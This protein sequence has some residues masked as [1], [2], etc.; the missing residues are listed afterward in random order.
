MKKLHRL[1]LFSFVS[2]GLVGCEDNILDIPNENNPDFARVY[3]TGPDVENVASGLYNAVF[4]GENNTNGVQ[5]MLATAADNV[6]CSFGNF[7]M[8][9]M[10]WEPRN[11]AWDNSPTY[12]NS[13]QTNNSYNRWYSAIGTASNVLRAIDGGVQIGANGADNNRTRAFAKFTLGLAY[14]NLALVFDRA[15]IVDETKTVDAALETA[16]PYE[17]VASAAIAYLEEALALSNESFTIPASWLG[18]PADVSSAD[19][20]KIINTSAARILSYLPRNNAAVVDVDWARVRAYA[21][22]GITADW[23]VLQDG[24]TRW[25][26]NSGDYLRRVGWGRTDMYV[27]NMMEPSLPAYWED[28]GDFPTPPEPATALDNRLKT[29]FQYMPSNDFIADRGYYHFSCYRLKRYD[30]VFQPNIGSKP[31]VA[32]AENDMLRAEA[33]AYLGDLAGAAAIINAGTRVTRGNLD[34]VAADFDDIIEAIHHERHVELHTTGF[35]VQ[36]FQMR[37]LDLLQIGTPLHL[38]LPGALLQNLGLTEFYTF[39]T[40]AAADGIGTSNGGWR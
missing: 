35:G 3:A 14:G 39:G 12:A 4:I 24:T 21:D 30:A 7:G 26:F 37:K 19:F 32:L 11:F 17:E 20:S 23:L 6:T 33:R 13:G 36:F 9:D 27:V 18:A 22:N 34:P 31:T 5:P 15:H 16:V 1:L 25:Y 8:R 38:P 28:R 10:S 29:D 40:V 2:A